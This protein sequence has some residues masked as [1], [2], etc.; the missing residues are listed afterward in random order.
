VEN[1]ELLRRPEVNNPV[2]CRQELRNQQQLRSLVTAVVDK[3][4]Q[5]CELVGCIP[6][7][8]GKQGPLG[9][10][11]ESKQEPLGKLVESKQEPLGKRK[12]PELCNWGRM[13]ESKELQCKRELEGCKKVGCKMVG[14]KKVGYKQGGYKQGGYKQGGYKQGDCKMVDCIQIG[15]NQGSCRKA[16]CMQADYMQE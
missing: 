10:L 3:E 5:C 1:K 2:V 16:D 9:K 15:Y 12:A 8:V 13:K 4:P 14:C 11:V 6:L 7:V